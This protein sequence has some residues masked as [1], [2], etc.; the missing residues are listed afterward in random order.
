MSTVLVISLTV[1]PA[2]TPAPRIIHAVCVMSG[3]TM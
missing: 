1:I 3:L 2:G